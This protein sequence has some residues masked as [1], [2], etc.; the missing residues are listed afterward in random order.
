MDTTLINKALRVNLIEALALQ[1]LP[2]EQKMRLIDSLTEMIGTKLMMRIG[3]ALSAEDQTAF[4]T[5]LDTGTE[6]QI[7]VWL[8][9]KGIDLDEMTVEEV[10]KTKDDLIARADAIA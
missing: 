6:E 9:T 5:A 4:E 1:S 10:A 2:E 8:K 7:R 3:E